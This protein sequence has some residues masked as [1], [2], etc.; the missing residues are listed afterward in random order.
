MIILEND[1]CFPPEY[2]FREIKSRTFAQYLSNHKENVHESLNMTRYELL[3][4]LACSCCTIM[5]LTL[6]KIFRFS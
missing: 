5:I 6:L 2:K 1:T 3:Y 4:R